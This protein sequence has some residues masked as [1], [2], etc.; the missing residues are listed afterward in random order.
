MDYL[1]RINN[2]VVYIENNL[3]NNIQLQDVAREACFSK[4]H[5]IRIFQAVTGET[6][7]SYVRKRRLTKAARDLI[8]SKQRILEIAIEYQFESPESFTR[9]F[10]SVYHQTPG[11]YRK[12]QV[13]QIAFSRARLTNQRLKHLNSGI[14]NS[15]KYTEIDDIRVVGLSGKTNMLDNQLYDL[16]NVFLQRMSE[17]KNQCKPRNYFEIHPF[18]TTTDVTGYT[19]KTMFTKI[20]SVEVSEIS[21]IPNSMISRIVKKGKYA[22]FTHVGPLSKIQLSYD[23]IWGTW[24]VGSN[25]IIDERDDFELYEEHRF[26]GLNHPE[27]EVDIYI[28]V[29]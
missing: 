10:K 22:V 13:N 4:Y 3:K 12:K 11:Q 15:P 19:E 20:A 25:E 8:E 24:V 7:W 6:V 16:W 1:E 5:F 9:S 17:I 26:K 23:Y 2:A 27:T 14:Q 18:E 28:P 21:C 29:K